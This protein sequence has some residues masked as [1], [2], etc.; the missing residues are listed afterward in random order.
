MEC[1]RLHAGD[2]FL[3]H[4]RSLLGSLIR[5]FEQ[6]KGEAK[7]NVNHVGLI[8]RAGWYCSDVRTQLRPQAQSTEALWRV[9][10]GNFP[11][12]YRDYKGAFSIWRP[13]FT[14]R[15]DDALLEKYTKK[16][17]GKRYGWW[18]L[19]FHAFKIEGLLRIRKR[20]ICS[21]LVGDVY[22]TVY[23]YQFGKPGLQL[24]PDDIED[25]ILSH[26]QDW[27]CVRPLLAP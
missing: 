15:V 13:R 10:C 3:T 22:E 2:V 9:R 5:R 19:I 14:T 12:L 8:T 23:R 25:W 7:S 1:M 27:D 17:C 4:G 11:E 26:P 6:E 24:D 20:P 21:S 18:K 16:Y